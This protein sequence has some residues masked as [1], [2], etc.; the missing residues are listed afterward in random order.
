MTNQTSDSSIRVEDFTVLPA[1]PVVTVRCITYNHARYIA[2]SIEGFLMQQVDFPFEILIGDDASTDGTVE[3]VRQYQAAHPELIRAVYQVENQFSKGRRPWRE[4]YF[5][6]ARGRYIAV[7]DGDDY[8]SDPLKLQKQVNFLEAHPDYALCFHDA[9]ILWDDASRAPQTLRPANLKQSY[10]LEDLLVGNFIPMLTTLYRHRLFEMLPAWYLEMPIGDWPLHILN[11]QYGKIGYLPE[12]MAVY[13][14]H[15]GGSWSSMDEGAQRRKEIRVYE[16]LLDN[17]GAEQAPYL[18]QGLSRLY[19]RMAEASAAKGERAAARR[20]LWQS[21][22]TAAR[23]P[24]VTGAERFKL[25]GKL[26]F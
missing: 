15:A 4:L 6:L 23:N 19:H 2:Q 10:A 26:V 7:C 24:L 22:L 13:R 5:N 17:L 20:W 1:A 14:L 8:W 12:V 21:V 25:L 3:I 16:M 11:A 9:T 18:R